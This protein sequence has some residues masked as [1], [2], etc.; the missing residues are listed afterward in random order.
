MRPLKQGMQVTIAPLSGG[1]RCEG[2]VELVERGWSSYVWVRV[3]N[4]AV[5]VP[6]YDIQ[7]ACAECCELMD[8]DEHAPHFIALCRTCHRH[9]AADTRGT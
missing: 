7:G 3:A 8:P 5:R 6:V 2:V 9:G 4:E 1:E